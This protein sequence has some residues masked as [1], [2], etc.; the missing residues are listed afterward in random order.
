[1]AVGA[2]LLVENATTN[3]QPKTNADYKTAIPTTIRW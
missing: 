3:Q 1:M 2:V